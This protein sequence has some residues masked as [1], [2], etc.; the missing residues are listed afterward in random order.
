MARSSR[1]LRSEASTDSPPYYAALRL[2]AG[3]TA[4]NSA[5]GFSPAPSLLQLINVLVEDI[6]ILQRRFGPDVEPLA[7]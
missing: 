2:C 6:F 7:G 3:R 1:P 4:L 5:N